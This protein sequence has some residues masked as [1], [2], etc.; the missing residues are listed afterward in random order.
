[1]LR[2]LLE[3]LYNNLP[4]LEEETFTLNGTLIRVKHRNYRKGS[5]AYKNNTRTR[6]GER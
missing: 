6:R 2:A 3:G 1:M 5:K 4:K